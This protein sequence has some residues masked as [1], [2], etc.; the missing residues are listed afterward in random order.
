[1]RVI[2]FNLFTNNWRNMNT[3]LKLGFNRYT[4]MTNQ[5]INLHQAKCT[6]SQ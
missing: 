4:Q 3:S 1:M 2:S 6:V 5:L